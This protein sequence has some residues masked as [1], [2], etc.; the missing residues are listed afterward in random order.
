MRRVLDFNRVVA[1]LH[2]QF[3]LLAVPHERLA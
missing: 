3:A 1:R 2:W